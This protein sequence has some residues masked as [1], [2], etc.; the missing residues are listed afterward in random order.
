[1]VDGPAKTAA[2]ANFKEYGGETDPK[3]K[4]GLLANITNFV[5]GSCW[6]SCG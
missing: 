6:R 3:K 2:L 1:M 4:E 5:T